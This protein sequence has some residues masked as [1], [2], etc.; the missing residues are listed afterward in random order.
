MISVAN[1][2]PILR[3]RKK[4][5]LGLDSGCYNASISEAIVTIAFRKT[6][7][8]GPKSARTRCIDLASSAFQVATSPGLGLGKAP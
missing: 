6:A 2:L 7:G 8:A 4:G 5:L 3:F 1:F